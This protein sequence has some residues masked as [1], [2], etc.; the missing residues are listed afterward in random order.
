MRDAHYENMYEHAARLAKEAEESD[1]QALELQKARLAQEGGS[2]PN[3]SIP[4]GEPLY[5]DIES[6]PPLDGPPPLDKGTK[7]ELPSSLMNEKS[8]DNQK[9]PQQ[10]SSKTKGIFKIFLILDFSMIL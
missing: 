8:D 10:K 1:R 7:I 2:A 6:N 4:K 9:S 3:D 5:E